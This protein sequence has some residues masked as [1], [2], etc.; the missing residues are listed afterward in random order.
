MCVCVCVCIVYIYTH[1]YIYI[2]IFILKKKTDCIH[3]YMCVHSKKKRC[4]IYCL[5]ILWVWQVSSLA[6][7]NL[8]S[9]QHVERYGLDD[10]RQC[11]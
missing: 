8:G 3:D 2:F 4:V 7:I 5:E 1:M 10:V 11:E 9:Q 6:V